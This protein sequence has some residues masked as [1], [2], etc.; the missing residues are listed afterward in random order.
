[1]IFV[2]W[3][4]SVLTSVLSLFEPSV[5]SIS[6]TLWLWAT[7]VFANLAEAIAEVSGYTYPP[8]DTGCVY[9]GK[10]ADY[11]V[12]LGIAAVDMEL[13]NHRDTDFDTNL[14]VLEV[15]LNWVR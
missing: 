5:F 9:S 1:M 6:V 11:A 15:L 7:L 13:T 8:I 14:R 12:A 2:V 4:G 3:V 10:L